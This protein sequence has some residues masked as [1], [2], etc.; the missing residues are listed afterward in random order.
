[1]K[2]IDCVNSLE[3]PQNLKDYLLLKDFIAEEFYKM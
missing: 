2:V 3:V 1:M